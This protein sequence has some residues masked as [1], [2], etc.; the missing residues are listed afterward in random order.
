MCSHK[1]IILIF[2]NI[3]VA[4][5]NLKGQTLFNSINIVIYWVSIGFMT[6]V[7]VSLRNSIDVESSLDELEFIFIVNAA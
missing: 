1:F 7:G 6:C 5:L 4:R 3:I 2:W